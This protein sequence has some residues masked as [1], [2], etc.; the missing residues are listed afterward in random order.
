MLN[1]LAVPRRRVGISSDKR[2]TSRS[3]LRLLP[4]F[5]TLAAIVV[6]AVSIGQV[7]AEDAQNLHFKFVNVA[8]STQGLSDFSQFP[9]ISNGGVVAFLATQNDT[10]QEV[11]RYAHHDAKAIAST[12]GS[13][14][15]FFADNLAINSAGVIAYEAGLNTGGRALGIFTSDG[16][17]TKTIINSTEQ[18]LPGF[19]IGT[20][21]I[22]DAG[23][24][25]FAALRNG[26]KSSLILTGDGGA[27]TQVFDSLNTS[28]TSFGAVAI[29]G[30]GQIVFRGVLPARN[31]GVF[32][33]NPASTQ[34][35]KDPLAAIDII[36][37]I[38]SGFFGFGD[39]VINN[40]GIVADSAGA[41]GKLEIFSGNV[42]GI[43]SRTD[44][45][46]SFFL[47][48]EHPS[49]N[50]RGAVAFSAI[51]ATGAQGIFVELTGGASPIA[52][53]QTGDSLFGSTVTAVSLG[54]FAFNDHFRLAFEYELEDGRS[55]IA[56]AS[57]E[58][59]KGH[60]DNHEDEDN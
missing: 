11:F 9:A 43:T 22:N 36:D 24:V 42:S 31:E 20:P 8:D 47:E 5:G 23:T 19:G 40:A 37:S 33:L 14:F 16:S 6:L 46:G 4:K 3:R 12:V 58:G 30:S 2:Q 21:S 27:L 53:L 54:R 55:G 18:G 10:E 49:I 45:T 51:E 34:T 35:T 57:L 15:T 32:V 17:V 48:F 56:V 59:D 26:L 7:F 28:F 41:P 25:A 38:N 44:P 39:P 13:Q 1:K 50:N 60:E 29:N 52:V